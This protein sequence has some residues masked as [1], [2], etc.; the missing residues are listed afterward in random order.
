MQA[1]LRCTPGSPGGADVILLPE[2]AY[3]MQR[4]CDKV[5][6]RQAAGRSFSIVVVAE[7]AATAGDSAHYLGDKNEGGMPR[8]GGVGASVAHQTPRA[9]ASRRG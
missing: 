4:V 3:D 8:L 9:R 6:R 1:G 7:G 2:I 5:K